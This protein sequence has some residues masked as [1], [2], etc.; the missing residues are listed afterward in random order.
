MIRDR[1][2]APDESLNVLQLLARRVRKISL[3]KLIHH[4]VNASRSR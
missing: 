2:P 3:Q 4:A 1:L